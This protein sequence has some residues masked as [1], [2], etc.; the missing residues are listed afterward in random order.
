MKHLPAF[1][2]GTLLSGLVI[3]YAVHAYDTVQLEYA[4]DEVHRLQ[5]ELD[6]NHERF[7]HD[8]SSTPTMDMGTNMEE[9]DHAAMH[10][11]PIDLSETDWSPTVALS[12]SEDPIS[13]WNIHLETTDFTFAPEHSGEE[14]IKGEG[15]AHLY[16]DDEKIARVYGPWFHL[17]ELSPG[18]HTIRVTLNSNDHHPLQKDGLGIDDSM[19]I[20]VSQ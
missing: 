16:V 9:H 4:E 10:D 13:G 17:A 7:A 12:V 15:H 3:G 1:L 2:L 8:E 20:D 18:K 5:H 11:M 19:N 6:P 14:H